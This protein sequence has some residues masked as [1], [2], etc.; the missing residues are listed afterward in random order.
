MAP[1]SDSKER[2]NPLMLDGV[3][4]RARRLIM[5]Q[6]RD[7]DTLQS[8]AEETKVLIEGMSRQ[9]DVLNNENDW[10]FHQRGEWRHS[11]IQCLSQRQAVKKDLK[12]SKRLMQKVRQNY[13]DLWAESKVLKE[14]IRKKD[15]E[16][17]VF[18]PSFF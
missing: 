3:D 4:E 6:E 16:I 18:I 2:V 9:I 15:E 13:F 7:L 10:L 17:K 1:P 12:D 14:T 5:S 8:T 11:Y